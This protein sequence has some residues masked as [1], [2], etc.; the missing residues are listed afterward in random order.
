MNVHL[1]C[2]CLSVLML[3]RRIPFSGSTK[4]PYLPWL[5]KA[6]T[7]LQCLHHPRTSKREPRL[8]P[9]VR[10]IYGVR[11]VFLF[12]TKKE[13]EEIRDD[14]PAMCGKGRGPVEKNLMLMII[15]G[16]L[17]NEEVNYFPSF[18]WDFH[19]LLFFG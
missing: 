4:E 11:N 5:A 1:T 15:M 16:Q 12:L 18:P 3:F 8:K 14:M 17:E 10:D 13:E 9:Q 7:A 6:L 19:S 2:M